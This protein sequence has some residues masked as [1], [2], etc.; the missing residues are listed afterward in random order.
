MGQSV[1]LTCSTDF[2]RHMIANI[3]WLDHAQSI[4]HSVT[5]ATFV[6]LTFDPISDSLHDA[7]YTCQVIH[8]NGT[9]YT[10]SIMLSVEGELF[11]G[12]LKTFEYS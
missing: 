2:P 4:V 10:E 3:D 12:L 5:M 1:S 7:K 9:K 11:Y 6:N 8:S